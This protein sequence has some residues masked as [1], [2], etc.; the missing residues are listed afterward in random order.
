MTPE[1]EAP[2]GAAERLCRRIERQLPAGALGHPLE[3]HAELPS[4]NDRAK[5][6]ALEGAP[7][8]A[9]VIAIA[10]TRGR[11]RQGRAWVSLPGKGLYL[12][13]LLRPGL[14]AGESAWLSVAAALAVAELLA[15]AGVPRVTVKAPNDVFAGGRKIAG[16]LVEPRLDHGRIEFAVVGIGLNLAQEP[17]DWCG[18]GVEE[19][20]TSCRME[21]IDLPPA[22]A[23]A[24]L[25]AGLAEAFRAAAGPGRAGL[26]ARWTA[27]GGAPD[28]VPPAR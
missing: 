3:V 27:L 11:G 5:A 12:S 24:R 18:T 10:Q 17:G 21:G 20:A 22:E 16:V 2:P 4:T 9:A 1:P 23:A 7:H 25:L 6:R 26:R 19:R 13:V 8:G 14:P 28:A 15:T